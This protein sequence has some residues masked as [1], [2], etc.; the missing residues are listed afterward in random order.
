[1]NG[2]EPLC[3][4]LRNQTTRDEETYCK[5]YRKKFRG[6]IR[7]IFLNYQTVGLVV[8]M[9]LI[10]LLIVSGNKVRQNESALS[11]IGFGLLGVAVFFYIYK[12]AKGLWFWKYAKYIVITNEG[13]WIMVCGALW[14]RKDFAGKKR[15]LS[16]HWSLYSWNSTKITTDEKAR[17][18]SPVKLANIFDDFD[19]AIIKSAHLKS[20]FLTRWDGMEEIDFLEETDAD[21]IVEY[22][23]EQRRIKR[24]KKKAD[25][26]VEDEND[27]SEEDDEN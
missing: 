18:R 22:A 16:P 13:I 25:E 15:F 11:Y 19:Y 10:G 26:I 4:Q 5:V 12:I 9:V 21:E 6:Y 8:L 3:L 20:L 7:H 23:R 27:N 1:M 2:K 14:K 24:N 17:P